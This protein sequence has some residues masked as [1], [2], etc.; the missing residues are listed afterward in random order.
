MFRLFSIFVLLSFSSAFNFQGAT[1]PMGYFDPLGFTKD[2]QEPEIARL[3]EA[4][5]KHGRWGMIAATAI[6]LSETV[7]STPAIHNFDDL[8]DSGKLLIVGAILAGELTLMKKGWKNPF[9][10]SENY[11]KLEEEYQPGDFGFK[12]LTSDD[13]SAN[14]LLNKELNNG[15]LAMLAASGMIAQELVTGHTL[16]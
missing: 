15:R 7:Q 3:R 10:G 9:V 1:R 12:T 5:L 8:S 14:E 6:P 4:E 11:F 2:L 13:E 16:F